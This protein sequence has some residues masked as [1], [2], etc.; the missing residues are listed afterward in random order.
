MGRQP[1]SGR[2]AG[3]MNKLAFQARATMEDKGY[4]P[5]EALLSIAQDTDTP[6]DLRIG[7]HKELCKYYAPQLK[8]MDVNMA[9]KG[10]IV[11]EMVNFC[12]QNNLVEEKAALKQLTD[13]IIDVG[14]ENDEDEEDSN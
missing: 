6:L 9:V 11:V 4:N 3:S 14:E 5:I 7:A 13:T 12:D 2:P 1:G 10:N 8:A